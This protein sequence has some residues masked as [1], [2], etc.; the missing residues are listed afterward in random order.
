MLKFLNYIC[1]LS[2]KYKVKLT[3]ET[4]TYAQRRL[5]IVS[6]NNL[7]SFNPAGYRTLLRIEEA[8]AL[9]RIQ[10]RHFICPGTNWSMY[11]VNTSKLSISDVLEVPR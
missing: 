1:Q 9:L 11:L 7:G 10:L 6:D 4:V 5:I 3:K 8:A 2:I